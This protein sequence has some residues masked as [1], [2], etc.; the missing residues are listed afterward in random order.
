[1]PRAL[2]AFMP[3][4]SCIVAAVSSWH[5]H[6]GRALK[7]IEFRLKRKQRMLVAGHSLIE[8]YSVLTRLPAPHRL[9]PKDAAALLKAN[10]TKKRSTIALPPNAYH[11]LLDFVANAG[12]SGGRVY[13]V[14]IAAFARQ[15]GAQALV[16]FNGAHFDG[17]A[18]DNL[19]IVVPE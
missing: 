4:T 10:F 8:A 9:S 13:D 6:H 19:E 2:A 1:M 11:T 3:D 12:V 15:G 14:L 18:G 17:L 7:E 16:T 5:E